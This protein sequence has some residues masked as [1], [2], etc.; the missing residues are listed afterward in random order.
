MLTKSEK[1][2]S[3]YTVGDWVVY[4]NTKKWVDDKTPKIFKITKVDTE[5]GV[6]YY[7][8]ADGKKD[9]VSMSYIRSA[10]LYEVAFSWFLKHY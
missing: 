8:T 2:S 7:K 6:V 4:E 3:L 9:T 10:K 1:P 5:F